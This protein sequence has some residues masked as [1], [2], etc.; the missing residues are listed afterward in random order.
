MKRRLFALALAS[1]VSLPALAAA[2]VSVS[3]P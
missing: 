3:D 1:L 2:Q